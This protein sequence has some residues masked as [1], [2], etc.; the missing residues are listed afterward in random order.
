MESILAPDV[1]PEPPPEKK[2]HRVF[3][4]LG[5]AL[6]LFL[7]LFRSW[8]WSYGF[9]SAEMLGPALGFALLP[10]LIAYLV[11]GRKSVRN[12]NRFAIYFSWLSLLFFLVSSKTPVS[13]SQHMGNL[14]KEAAGTKPVDSSGP[15]NL[16]EFVRDVMR[17]VLD[18]RKSFEQETSAFTV[19]LEGLYSV[20]SF[21][22]PDNMKRSLEAVRGVVAADLRYSQQIEDLPKRI[23]ARVQSSSLSDSDKRDFMEGLWKSFGSLKVLAIHRQAM[24]VEKQWS[25][26]TVGLYEFTLANS[27]KIVVEHGHLV[28]NNEKFRIEF[29]QR[30]KQSKTLQE[31]LIALNAQLET[32]QNDAL[33]E[34]GV[35][36]K[37]LGLPGSG[38]AQK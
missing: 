25:D 6:G 27:G 23:E 33:K 22:S 36:P 8:V 20:K 9:F 18:Q 35:T 11:A 16:D 3:A 38:P 1:P 2:R 17:D 24:E 12:F 28:A 4:Y 13:L 32:A 14:M 30:L 7:A 26:A 10:A 19:E 34:L 21:S 5:I 15:R 37:D 31:N 29:N